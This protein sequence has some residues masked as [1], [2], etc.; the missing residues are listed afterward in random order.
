M[1]ESSLPMEVTHY[2]KKIAGLGC[3]FGARFRPRVSFRVR[4][5][6]LKLQRASG[7]PQILKLSQKKRKWWKFIEMTYGYAYGCGY[8]YTS[9]AHTGLT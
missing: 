8:V 2:W 9:R 3:G 5:L 6:G 1:P 4:R 7:G